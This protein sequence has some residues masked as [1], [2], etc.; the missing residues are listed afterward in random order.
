MRITVIGTGYLGAVHAAC[1]AAIGHEVLGVDSDAEKI[2]ELAAGRVPF[3]E[4]GLSE[5]LAPAVRSGQLRFGVSYAEAGH[6][7]EIHFI[8]VGTPQLAGS[9]AADVSAVDAAIEKL[10]PHCARD[11]LIVGKSTVPVG[12]AARLADVIADLNPDGCSVELAWNPEFLREGTAVRDTLHPDRLVVGVASDQADAVL[13]LAYAPMIGAGTPYIVTDLSTAEM[14]KVSANAFLA[15]KVSFINMI[16]DICDVADADVV[17][18]AEA[19][20]HDTRIGSQALGAGLGFGGG[21]LAKDVRALAARAEELG[22]ADAVA[23]LGTVDGTNSGR[24]RRAIDTARMLVGGSFRDQ[25]VGILGV[26]FKPDTDD[27]RDSPAL[28]VARAIDSQGAAVRVH[29]PQAIENARARFPHLSYVTDVEKACDDADIVLHLTEWREYQDLDPVALRAVV[30]NP[31]IFDARNTLPLDRWHD[32]GWTTRAFGRRI[33]L[34][35]SADEPQ[36]G[37]TEATGG[38]APAGLPPSGLPL[39]GP[40]ARARRSWCE[41]GGGPCGCW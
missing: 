26:A 13:R 31:R 34:P 22:A 15:T 18:L 27:V 11:C 12:T 29:D 21:C 1:M 25:H 28:A 41:Q 30:R 35:R 37:V 39:G 5:I 23:F 9:Y 24:R 14:V 36:A 2:A 3:F 40:S 16:A 20:G 19:L 8:C 17:T 38:L 10:V 4:P 33:P 6:F 32:A 7:G